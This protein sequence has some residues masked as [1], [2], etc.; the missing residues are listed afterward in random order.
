MKKI[1]QDSRRAF[2][3]SGY[4]AVACYISAFIITN[5]IGWILG[6]GAYMA[7]GPGIMGAAG[8]LT[9]IWLL[10]G[11]SGW[12]LFMSYRLLSLIIKLVIRLLTRR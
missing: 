1:A 3:N 12:L 10:G 6:S 8:V 7:M 5:T 11:I 2:A 4:I 9:L